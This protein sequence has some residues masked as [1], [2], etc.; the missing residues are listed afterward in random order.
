VHLPMLI[1]LLCLPCQCRQVLLMT[2]DEFQQLQQAEQ[3]QQLQQQQQGL[4]L[5]RDL[6]QGEFGELVATVLLQVGI[7]RVDHCGLI[8]ESSNCSCCNCKM[9]TV[10]TGHHTAW[11]RKQSGCWFCAWAAPVCGSWPKMLAVHMMQR[12]SNGHHVCVLCQ[13]PTLSNASPP[14]PCHVFELDT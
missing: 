9:Y 4:D 14:S 11:G 5:G 3:E 7:R 10:W 12:P 8:Y 13:Y 1:L 2:E 6:L